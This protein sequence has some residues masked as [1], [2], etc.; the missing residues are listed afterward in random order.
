MISVLT[1]AKLVM[2]NACHP[3]SGQRNVLHSSTL[4]DIVIVNIILTICAVARSVPHGKKKTVFDAWNG[5]HSVPLHKDDRH[6]TTFI[7]PWG[8]YRYCTAPQRDIASGDGYSRRYDEIVAHIPR[9]TKCILTILFCGPTLLKTASSK[10]HNGWMF[11][12]EMESPSTLRSLF[13]C[14]DEV[15]FAGFRISLSNVSPCQRYLQAIK[16]FPTP[17]NITD[18]RSWFGLLNQ[19]SYAFSMGKRLQPLRQLLKPDQKFE[20]SDPI[21]NL[22]EESKDVIIS[23][24]DE[25]VRIFDKNKPTGLATDSSKD[26]IGV[27]LL[28]KHCN[29][30]KLAPLC[31][32]DGWQITLVGSRFTHAAESGYAPIEGEALAV[33]DALD[34]ARFFVLR[35]TNL[36]VAVDYKPLLK[37]LGD[38]SLEDISNN[39]LKNLKEKTLRY[40]FQILHV[41]GAKHKAADA[42]SRYPSGHKQPEMLKLPDDIASLNVKHSFLS[43]KRQTDEADENGCIDRDIKES[44]VCALNSLSA[45]TWQKVRVA[46]SSDADMNLLLATIESGIPK[47]RHEMAQSIREY[48]TVTSNVPIWKANQRF[49]THLTRSI[50]ASRHLAR[51]TCCP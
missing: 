30:E 4:A 48:Q 37:I 38:R 25:G 27:W 3:A 17:K 24:I 46:T 11:V 6:Y 10:Q 34:K 1:V 5:Y 39:R 13:F 21:N 32:R 26:G 49:Y 9:K 40:K 8:R 43:K 42:M 14:E 15:E 19:V 18:V 29:C 20:W 47:Y 2:V 22:F 44:T 50:Q 35:C 23:E 36:I 41:P 33:A 7:T 31:C 28:Q 12:V 45:V 16:D 51:N